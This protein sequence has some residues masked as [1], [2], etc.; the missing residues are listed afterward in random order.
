MAPKEAEAIPLP[1]EETTPPVTKT[2]RFMMSHRRLNVCRPH[3]LKADAQTRPKGTIGIRREFR[4]PEHAH[5]DN[6]SKRY[7]TMRAILA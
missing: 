7:L 5:P 2:N 4:L 3:E 6:P 1:S